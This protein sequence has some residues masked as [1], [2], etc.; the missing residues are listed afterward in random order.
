[1]D[2][3]L[4]HAAIEQAMHDGVDARTI[5]REYK[6]VKWVRGKRRLDTYGIVLTETNPKLLQRVFNRL[7]TI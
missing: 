3:D 7:A 6:I 2:A 1:M 4:T 5:C